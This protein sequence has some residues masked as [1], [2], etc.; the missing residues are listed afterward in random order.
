MLS[1]S[2]KRKPVFFW[3]IMQIL[4]ESFLAG[5]SGEWDFLVNFKFLDLIIFAIFSKIL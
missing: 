2:L 1:F 4:S 5:L 3:N